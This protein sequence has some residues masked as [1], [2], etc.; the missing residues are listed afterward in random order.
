MSLQQELSQVIATQVRL[1]LSPDR[2]SA[3]ARRQTRNA[4]ASDLYLRA[5]DFANQR[6][7]AANSRAIDDLTRATTLDPN[8]ALAWAGLAKVYSGGPLN[9]DAPPLP[10]GSRARDAAMKAVRLDPQLSEAQE[11]LGH[12]LWTFSWDWPAA[13]RAL[14]Q[15]V[16]L[17]PLSVAGHMTL[18]HFLSQMGQHPKPGARCVSRAISTRCTR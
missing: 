16:A 12:S 11:A 10:A 5:R 15:A 2:L 14:R 18:G 4:E 6:T 8:Y 17:D 9:A 13:E 3:L 1:R 7:A